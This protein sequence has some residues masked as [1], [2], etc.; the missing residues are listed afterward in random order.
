MRTK[1]L[2]IGHC[3]GVAALSLLA[4]CGGSD[5]EPAAGDGG[6]GAQAVALSAQNEPTLSAA[7]VREFVG[8]QGIASLSAGIA[9]GQLSV[10]SLPVRRAIVAARQPGRVTAQAE[11]TIND[12]TGGG[13]VAI[14]VGDDLLSFKSTFNACVEEGA[15]FNG[16]VN[17]ALVSI[18]D[19]GLLQNFDATLTALSVAA[20]NTAAKLNGSLRVTLDTSTAGQTKTSFSSASLSFEQSS[21][22]QVQIS[23]TLSNALFTD[24][25][26][27]AGELTDTFSFSRSGTLAALGTV[28]Y[29]A[30]T[31]TALVTPA[32]ASDPTSGQVKVTVNG[33]GIILITAEATR[34]RVQADVEGNG[35]FEVDRFDTWSNLS[36]GL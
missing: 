36:G 15:T 33:T 25:R 16:A 11:P 5:D 8:A 17:L 6:N 2:S 4:A 3:L 29:K 35:S 14:E 22:G 26:S 27:D 9:P 20:D 7:A 24:I 28:A 32:G 19:D 30:E 23:S 34:V 10:A 18:S 31:V 13:T 12:C 21:G 1:G